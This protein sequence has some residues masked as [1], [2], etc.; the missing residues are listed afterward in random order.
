MAD[1]AM[2]TTLRGKMIVCMSSSVAD[3]FG[4]GISLR[5]F[6]PT[7]RLSEEPLKRSRRDAMTISFQR[8]RRFLRRESVDSDSGLDYQGP[9]IHL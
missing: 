1:A 5:K 2:A 7:E 3:S 6:D 4:G 8:G 9:P